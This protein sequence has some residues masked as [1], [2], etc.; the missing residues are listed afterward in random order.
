M[1][2]KC[3]GTNDYKNA[4]RFAISVFTLF[5]SKIYNVYIVYLMDLR[6]EKVMRKKIMAIFIGCLISSMMFNFTYAAE[7]DGMQESRVHVLYE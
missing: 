1:R 2:E 7:E 4:M 3:R 6:R 5:C